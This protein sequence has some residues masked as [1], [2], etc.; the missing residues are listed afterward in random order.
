MSRDTIRKGDRGEDVLYAQERL[1]VH[2]ACPALVE[3]GIFGDATDAATREFQSAEGLA[4]DGIIGP[5]TWSALEEDPDQPVGTALRFSA[6]SNRTGNQWLD[7]MDEWCEHANAIGIS[8]IALMLDEQTDGGWTLSKY[9]GDPERV[10]AVCDGLRSHG[11]VPVLV[12]W[13]VPVRAQIDKLLCEMVDL[14][15]AADARAIELDVEGGNW[16]SSHVE[17]F[18]SLDDAAR[19]LGSQLY[20]R[21]EHFGIP[22]ATDTHLGR[23][24]PSN[25][26]L[27]VPTGAN[28][29]GCGELYVQ[30][31]SKYA[32]DE[33]ERW[34]GAKY[35]PGNMQ[36]E[37]FYKMLDVQSA[38]E[39]YDAPEN[40]FMGIAG[41]SQVYPEHAGD[42]R[43]RSGEESILE[44][45]SACVDMAV[46]DI[47]FWSWK[48]CVQNEYVGNA[49]KEAF[50]RWG[51]R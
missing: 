6:W 32:E 33:P 50:R 19:Y 3:D 22:I 36:R 26:V 42:G 1:N 47:R 2:G 46:Y 15:F 39:P 16:S 7:S 45:V 35:G 17:D 8:E 12:T 40:L 29:T 37:G 18:D 44:A 23:M 21:A 38:L 9:G 13:P 49:M 41:Y 43:A 25:L 34:W 48:Y 5:N 14:A 31:Y 11:I 4:V 24:T 10:I 51:R 30:A 20:T 28:L 27:S